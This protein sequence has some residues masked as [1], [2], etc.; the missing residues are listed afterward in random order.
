MDHKKII[1]ALSAFALSCGAARVSDYSPVFFSSAAEGQTVDAVSFDKTSGTLTL[2]GN[3]DADDLFE[4][5]GRETVKTIT[6]AE[7]SVLPENCEELFKG[8]KAE[9]IDLS[10]ADAAKVK[11]MRSMFEDCSQ[12]TSVDLSGLN[13]ANVT[14]MNSMFGSCTALASLDLSGFD[15]SKVTD[16]NNM[17]IGC[18]SLTSLNVSGFDTSNVTGMSKMFENCSALT[19]LDVTCFNTSKVG[20]IYSMFEGC[21]SLKAIDVSG[22][23][24]SSATYMFNMFKGCSSLTSLDVSVFNTANVLS[25]IGMFRDCSSLITLDISGFTADS[26]KSM[27]EAAGGCSSMFENCF[28][29]KTI[30]ANKALRF[31]EDCGTDLFVGCRELVGGNGTKFG[32]NNTGVLYARVDAPESP[33]Y[34]TEKQQSTVSAASTAASSTTTSTQASTTTA[35]VTTSTSAS[36][37]ATVKPSSTAT[38]TASTTAAVTKTTST[39]TVKPA[40]Y[41]LGD[42][43]NNGMVDAVDSSLVLAYY[44]KISTHSDGGFTDIQKKAADM[45]GDGQIDAVDASNILAYYARVSTNGK[46]GSSSVVTTSYLPPQD[47]SAD[48]STVEGEMTGYLTPQD[49][50][51]KGDGT[52]DDTIAFRKL[53]KAAYEASF[54]A[55]DGWVHTKAIFIPSG[56]Y[57]ITDTIIDN[58]LGVRS[59][60]FEVKGAGRE[61]TTICFSAK[62]LFDNRNVFAFTTFSGIEFYGDN[63][64]TF[65]DLS[66]PDQGFGVQRLQFISCSFQKCNKILNCYNSTAM[67]SEVTFAYCKISECGT[68]DNPC[69]LFTLY[70]QQSVDWR[71]DYTDIESFRGD[72]FYYAKGANVFITGGSIIPNDG[73]VFFF[74]FNTADRSNYAGESNSPHILCIGDCFEIRGNSSL[75]RTTSVRKDTATATFKSC[76][77]G[78][79]ANNSPN[80]LAIYGGI[81]AVFENCYE[82]G[83]IR[84][85]GD[86]SK[87]TAIQPKIKFVD[88][89]NVNVDYLVSNSTVIP[90]LNGLGMN[91]CHITVDDD[92]D[93]YLSNNNNYDPNDP[94]S[95]KGDYLHS[96]MGL[97]ECRQPVKLSEYDYITL[98]NGKTV[99][100]KPFGFVKYVELTVPQNDAYG[101]YFP[102]TL[103]L[104]DNGKQI[105]E[106]LQLTFEKSQVY[107]LEI[108][109]Y[110]EELQF[111]FTH[112]L[113]TTPH[114]NMNMEI[115][116]F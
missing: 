53:F 18:T 72:A 36:S 107:K 29:L 85:N 11:N 4:Y 52:S 2:N 79:V 62:V 78:T 77:L 38:T 24:T 50:G 45:N 112:S 47:Q 48:I 110:V 99:T 43:D 96:V 16:M 54:R 55:A 116:K 10:K 17:F 21:S 75:I 66:N 6:A 81:N 3:I 114:I 67:L 5:M 80:F 108:N 91:N 76:N 93:F 41:K 98:T 46:S 51:A 60:M 32:P 83:H 13:T 33:G 94:D 42:V 20:A 87:E 92:Y 27:N 82:C 74:D 35:A 101:E 26:L 68:K 9:K 23:D 102:V 34:F 88:C 89:S 25:T 49:F 7:G 19:A 14:N 90:A 105:G 39:T 95:P 70:C 1:A 65:M 71:F 103:T 37:T 44:A 59:G 63:T 113:S 109:D 111:K 15:T 30:F 84:I 115:V 104:Y 56:K 22:F 73:N 97:S 57:I 40:E 12:L 8:S 86:F 106:P 100:A 28:S 64:N 58:D 31:S 61:S 69:R